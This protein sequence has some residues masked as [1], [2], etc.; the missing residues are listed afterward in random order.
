M[1]DST[2]NASAFP[3]PR[4]EAGADRPPRPAA[5]IVVIRDG[6]NG[7]E[8]LLSRRAERG[9]H[10]SNAWVFPGGV[11]EARDAA[12]HDCCD[13]LDDADASLR[14]GLPSGGLD[15][16]VAAVRECF[17]E[18]GL[19]FARADSEALVDLDGADAARLGPWRGALHRGEQGIAELCAREGLSLAVDELVYLSHWLT[20]LGRPKRFDTRFF[21]AAAPVAQTAAHDGAELVEQLWIAPADALA[22]SASLKLLTPTQKSLETVARFGTVADAMAWAAAPRE[23]A[24]VMPRVA[25]GRDG[26]R[27][28]LPSEHA[29]AELG[30]I[31]PAGHG[32]GSYDIVTDRPVRL[33]TRVIRV[34]AG[35]SSVMTGPGTNTYL[36]GDADGATWAVIDPGPA[37]DAHVD[38]IVAAAPGPIDRI[39]VTHTHNDHSPAT[40]ALKARTGAT[41]LGL[42]PLH[43]EWQ[44]TTFAAD[45]TLRGGERIALGAS[46]HLSVIHTPGHA[47]N[48]LCYLLEEEKTLFTGDHV[49]QASTVVI[50]PPD[51]DMALY[52][53]SLRS[54]L[55]LDLDW[56]APGHGFLMAQPRQAMEAIV[57]HRLKR[58]AKVVDALEALGPAP[59]P[60][61]LGHVY[62][63]VPAHLHPMALRS[64]TAHLLKLQ[65]ER[66]AGEAEGRWSLQPAGR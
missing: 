56:L 33:S 4:A 9:D 44:D 51:G 49:M 65:A 26:F 31:D 62:A 1:P 11:V 55:D 58:E 5:T 35:N 61:L 3:T 18:S 15:Y 52:L 63:D 13:G 28:V 64:L 41:V 29:W 17:E 8:V 27:P 38:A 37:L 30:R 12:A 2:A 50:N 66:R 60:E 7:I 14:L 47:S 24:L 34:S 6:A 45:V 57:A 36:V 39:F 16:Y 59:M 20:P 22:R 53:A 25:T 42:A 46:T 19:L 32:H 23:V 54:L 21:I 43:R 40:P 10:N 48:H